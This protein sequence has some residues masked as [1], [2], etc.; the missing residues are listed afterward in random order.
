M[1]IKYDIDIK[2]ASHFQ[3]EHNQLSRDPGQ[4]KLEHSVH[5]WQPS[6]SRDTLNDLLSTS[7]RKLYQDEHCEVLGIITTCIL[8]PFS[9]K[10]EK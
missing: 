9:R 2:Q 1:G 10:S 3:G 7:V 8:M 5:Q 4:H 6:T